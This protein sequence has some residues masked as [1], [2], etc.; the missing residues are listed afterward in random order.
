MFKRIIQKG[1]V[2]RSDYLRALLSDT[3][4]ADVPII[5]SNDGFYKNLKHRDEVNSHISEF[6][7][8]VL[9]PVRPYT[10]P[11]RY[12]ILRPSGSP[13]GLSLIHPAAQ[14]DVAAFYRD[15]GH[16]ICYYAR[17]SKATI[18]APYKVASLF[19]VR[20]PTS[21]V[22]VLKDKGV[23]TV[24]LEDSVANP[25]SYF[26][27]R[28]FSRAYQFFGSADYLR[29][30]KKFRVS[31][32][33]DIAR[34]FSS[35]YTH[36]MYWAIVGVLAAKENTSAATFSNRFDRL[37]QSMNFNET[38]GICV[39]AEVSRVFAELIL[40]EVDRR[41]IN[42][43]ANSDRPLSFRKEYEF[44][45]YVDDYYIFAEN[46]D[47]AKRVM[48]A[49]GVNLAVFNLHLSGDKTKKLDRPFITEKSRVI[50]D[51]NINLANFTHK[52]LRGDTHDKL[53]FV[54][55]QR[56]WRSSSLLRG[57]LESMKASCFDHS[58]GYQSSSDYVI[59]ALSGRIANL[60]GTVEVAEKAGKAD[61]DTYLPAVLVLLEASFFFYSVNPTVSSSHKLAQACILGLKLITRMA[62]H[63]R[64]MLV[65]QI[66]RWTNQ[67]LRALLASSSHADNACVPLEVL[68]VLL[69][70]GDINAREAN[71]QRTIA[72]CCQ[73]VAS[74]GY[75]EIVSYL[76][77]IRDNVE[78]KDL[79]KALF[80][81][82]RHIIEARLGVQVDSESAHLALDLLAC[83]YLERDRRA[84]FFNNLRKKVGLSVLPKADA[85]A[86]VEA[87]E[88]T[89]W[90]VNWR[91]TDLLN[92]I[93]KK[94]LS[95]VY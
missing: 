46:D 49:V 92:L 42:S 57:F 27:Y 91:E 16:L 64:Q 90:F 39:G 58:T 61:G 68:N 73:N 38:N 6:A 87:C 60:W 30:E 65:E 53:H 63:R 11:Y 77:C 78:H 40:G 80:K 18:R 37:M 76:F 3:T 94:E 70:V 10:V 74:A 34:C 83:P 4:P 93:R 66:V 82:G 25:A 32:V 81:R 8:K 14:V 23:D 36:T 20:G 75:F 2:H 26:A 88:S 35:I 85:L 7:E 15:V 1:N 19:F 12:G 44:F 54:Y 89:P 24:E 31:Y 79:Q 29:L 47:V 55:P 28:G 48:D 59:A 86:A 33:T 69:V 45:R 17:R 56:I 5:V 9:A 84:S 50:R 71:A 52:F 41:T 13:R 21:N 62:P 72:D 43:L 22:N 51:A 67:V 95:S